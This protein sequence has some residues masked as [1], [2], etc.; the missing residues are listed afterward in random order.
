MPR[1]DARRIRKHL[2]QQVEAAR[3][4]GAGIVTFRAGDVHDALG[5]TNSYANVCQ[6][7]EG[8]LFHEGAGVEIATYVYRP[9][10]GRGANLEIRFRILP[11]ARESREQSVLTTPTSIN[12]A[13]NAD[14]RSPAKKASDEMRLLRYEF[15]HVAAIE[16][17]QERDGSPREFL[18]R[19]DY[20]YAETT[21]LNRYGK[22]PFCRF[23]VG[24]LPFAS[25]VY[26]LTVDD[27]LA[28]VGA[29]GNLVRR[30]GP[31]GYANISPEACYVIGQAT[32]CKVNNLILVAARIGRRIDL[33]IC[34][35]PTP[36]PIEASLLRHLDPPW[37]RPSPSMETARMH[38]YPMT[39]T[40]PG[41]VA[42]NSR[43][44]GCA[45]LLPSLLLTGLARLIRLPD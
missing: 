5:L 9:P 45:M 16:P 20:A 8:W 13:G 29:T 30:W 24:G 44:S 36:V 43:A 15:V 22:G 27:G 17:E 33:W 25:G 11:T 21:P 31:A 19:A 40:R 42:R 6:V 12:Y 23:D 38:V 2:C 1:G 3:F 7:L 39:R 18:P 37:N 26:A 28:Y 34:E 32:Y 35:A 41:A 4:E 10:S 14:G